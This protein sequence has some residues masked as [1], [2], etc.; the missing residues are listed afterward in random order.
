MR[1]DAD[2]LKRSNHSFQCA[3]GL[4]AYLQK[5][6]HQVTMDAGHRFIRRNARNLERH[7]MLDA[8]V[9]QLPQCGAATLRTAGN[10]ERIDY[11]VGYQPDWQLALGIWLAKDP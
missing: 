10:S 4:T 9:N 1:I 5:M 3:K 6:R 2:A 11:L 8:R 7:R